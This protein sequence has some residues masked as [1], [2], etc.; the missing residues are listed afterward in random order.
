MATCEFLS[1]CP[2][3][4]DHMANKPATAELYKQH[5]CREEP[6]EC[7]RLIVRRA[8]GKEAVPADLLPNAKERALEIVAKRPA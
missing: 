6:Q 1:A 8:C 7:A 2:F 4:N 5:Y 3:F